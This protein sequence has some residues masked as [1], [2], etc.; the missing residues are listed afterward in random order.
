MVH[1]DTDY[2]IN[3]ATVTLY[4]TTRLYS[5][6]TSTGELGNNEFKVQG[7]ADLVL[8]VD[9]DGYQSNATDIPALATNNYTEVKLT[10][11]QKDLINTTYTFVNWTAI[12]VIQNESLE[13][14]NV[15]IRAEMERKF[16]MG[17]LELDLNNWDLVQG[18]VD[19]WIEYLERKSLDQKDTSEFLTL[20]DRFYELDTASYNVDI[21]GAIGDITTT[22]STINITTFYSYNLV[23]ELTYI[24]ATVFGLTLNGTYDTQTAD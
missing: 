10:P 5:N 9:A 2:P 22:T 7:G 11:S 8:I 18:E 1:H 3:E 21:S 6:S 4:D 20:D 13:V 23:G 16:G 14:D 24:N 15:S 17:P 12:S 19:D